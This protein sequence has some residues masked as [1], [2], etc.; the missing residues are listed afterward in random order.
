MSLALLNHHQ[1]RQKLKTLFEALQTIKTL[2]HTDVR[3]REMLEVCVFCDFFS[4]MTWLVT[5]Q[6]QFTAVSCS[7]IFP[8]FLKIIIIGSWF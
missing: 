2:Q 7:L 6:S 5:I 3:L 8:N 1:K 4:C